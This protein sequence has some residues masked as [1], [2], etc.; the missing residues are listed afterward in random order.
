MDPQIKILYLDD[1]PENIIGFKATFEKHYTIFKAQNIHEAKEI[2]A[3]EEIQIA[4]IDFKMPEMDGVDFITSQQNSNKEIVFI[5][6]SAYTEISV[7]I[8]AINQHNIY[9]F[10]EKP[11]NHDEVKL[12][13]KNASEAY[14]AKKENQQLLNELETKNELLKKA[15]KSERRAHELKKAFLENLSHEIRT[16]LNA[17]L[18]FNQLIAG[19]TDPEKLKN[20]T[21]ASVKSGYDLL[22]IIDSVLEGS[23][24]IT[25]QTE[26]K[27]MDMN[28]DYFV[29]ESIE[30]INNK[31]DNL[32]KINI[33]TDTNAIIKIDP[34]KFG[35]A[36]EN[37]IENACKYCMGNEVMLKTKKENGTIRIS[38]IDK[39]KG[40]EAK[41]LEQIFEPFSQTNK[42]CFDPN[43]GIGMG[44]FIAKKHIENMN[45]R[46]EVESVP[47]KGSTF[48]II[49]PA[50]EQEN[51]NKLII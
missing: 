23:K 7:V 34:Q 38:V 45:G 27:L 44:L 25:S 20:Y 26:Y 37:I 33:S 3:K 32:P 30:I 9:G 42:T 10:I 47:G 40:I 6:I 21:D 29:S 18:G 8:K 2:L 28:V 36:F 15:I 1:E 24:L 39:G 4:L 48:T 13:L 5:I 46:L 35:L 17:I 16:P 50:Q 19:T 43:E 49:L 51:H 22:K 11:W 31:I 12:M 41:D 14:R